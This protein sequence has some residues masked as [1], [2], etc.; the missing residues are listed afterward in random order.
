MFFL[1][2]SIIIYLSDILFSN[3]VFD[4]G[5]ESGRDESVCEPWQNIL[6]IIYFLKLY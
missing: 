5:D 6:I 3:I 1:Q 4:D 2:Y